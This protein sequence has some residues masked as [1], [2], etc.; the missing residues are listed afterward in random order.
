MAILHSV[1]T[2]RRIGPVRGLVVAQNMRGRGLDLVDVKRWI[3]MC[4]E[5][6]KVEKIDL[7]QYAPRAGWLPILLDEARQLGVRLSLRTDCSAPP[8]AFGPLD[9]LLDVFLTPARIDAPHLERWFEACRLAGLPVR[10][11]VQGPFPPGFEAAAF[12]ARVAESGGVVANVALADPFLPPPSGEPSDRLLD[13]IAALADAF[14]EAGLESAI[15][16]VP[17][18]LLSEKQRARVVNRPQ[19]ALDHQQYHGQLYRFAERVFRRSP[20]MIAKAVL[21]PL[22]RSSSYTRSIDE[23]MLQWILRR[24]YRHAFFLLYSKFR[25]RLRRTHGMAAPLPEDE[26]VYRREAARWAETKD[27]ALDPACRA[28]RLRRI[29]DGPTLTVRRMAPR[30]VVTPEPGDL[31]LYPL[32][33]SGPTPKHYDSVDSE[34][35]HAGEWQQRLASEADALMANHPATRE[36]DSMDYGIEGQWTHHMPGGNRWYSFTDTEKLSTPLARCVPPFTLAATFGGGIA[37]LAGFSF[38]RHCKILCPMESYSHRIALHVD[39]DGRYVLLRDGLPVRPTQ[40]EGAPYA[41]ARLAGVVEPRLCLWNINDSIITQCVMLWEGNEAAMQTLAHVRYSVVVVST[42]YSRRLQAVLQALAHQHDADLRELEVIVCYAPGIDATDDVLESMKLAHPGLRIVRAPFDESL[43]RSKGLML[44]EAVRAASGEWII[45][46]D[47]DILVPPT[48]VKT[49]GQLSES[50]MFAASNG[51]KMLSAETTA[52]VLLGEVQPWRDWDALMATEGE[53]RAR[54]AQGVP[55]GFFQAVRR[56][57]FEK[58]RYTEL[59]HFEG[60]DWMFGNDMRKAFGVETRLT[61]LTVLHM[62]HG[63]SQWYGTQKQR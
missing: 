50:C 6:Y 34:R 8:E 41:P 32:H 28:C 19:L 52:R 43:A 46:M 10:I 31:V 37:E 12:A 40:F 11:Q 15:L 47:S 14:T 7:C 3:R 30:A 63:G 58:V 35:L 49:F 2:E 42:R 51:R 16:H 17:F 18:C 24:S 45:L 53:F 44:N 61:D 39:S 33:F 59:G 22:G 9:G 57:C 56:G 4:V 60:A 29:C 1:P 23:F 36:I 48:M 26:D 54:E 25:R 38:G 55:I 62:D 5:V 13:D 21:V 27:A 20:G